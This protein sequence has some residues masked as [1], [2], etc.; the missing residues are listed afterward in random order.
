MTGP[1]PPVGLQV[2]PMTSDSPSGDAK[3]EIAQPLPPCAEQEAVNI[4]HLV[5]RLLQEGDPEIYR[6]VGLAVDRA[7][8]RTA[9]LHTRGNQVLASQLLG[10]SRTTLR[11][12]LRKLG[13][14][15]EK[16]L[17]TDSLQTE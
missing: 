3:G 10:I 12:K 16:Q 5:A 2:K 6:K 15:I 11:A 17:S 7:V 4:T 14:V 9:L 1:G 8:M 13:I